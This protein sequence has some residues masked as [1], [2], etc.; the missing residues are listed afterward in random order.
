MA[1]SHD[2]RQP[3]LSRIQV[4]EQLAK[5][6]LNGGAFTHSINDFDDVRDYFA[7]ER[8]WLAY[9]RTGEAFVHFGIAM[10]QL[11]I[12][13]GTHPYLGRSIAVATNVLGM[14]ISIMGAVRYSRQD[15]AF[16][17]NS[18]CKKGMFR[19]ESHNV[20]ICAGIGL[21]VTIGL[22]LSVSGYG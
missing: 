12:L 14:F 1:E 21:A 9:L 15:A 13:R 16:R 22:W 7:L 4:D 10:A 3:L 6:W 19:S 11:F 5:S 17:E 20:H 8:T 18:S 2:E